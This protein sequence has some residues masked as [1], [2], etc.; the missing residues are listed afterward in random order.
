MNNERIPWFYQYGWQLVRAGNWYMGNKSRCGVRHHHNYLS[1]REV[2]VL[3]P[4]EIGASFG[5]FWAP[6]ELHR[7]RVAF[8]VQPPK[9]T[10]S[11]KTGIHSLSKLGAHTIHY[12]IHAQYT[13]QNLPQEYKI[14]P[15]KTSPP[16][17]RAVS[18]WDTSYKQSRKYSTCAP[19]F[20]EM[21]LGKIY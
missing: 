5:L 6:F 20:L 15:Q 11:Y 17:Q 8:S 13:V 4:E 7:T 19:A 1:R 21:L 3:F 2:A 12:V 16:A 9:E 14:P 18:R 10:V